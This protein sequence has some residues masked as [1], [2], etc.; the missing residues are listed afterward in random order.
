[1]GKRKRMWIDV[2]EVLN[3]YRAKVLRI[4]EGM[5]N[6]EIDPLDHPGTTW[7]V[8]SVFNDV[9]RTTL[10]GIA[11][12]SGFCESLLVREGAQAAIE[13]LRQHVDL[14]VVTSPF[15]SRHWVFERDEWLNKYFGFERNRVVHTSAK[16]LIGA[17][18]CLDDKHSNVLE[19]HAEHPDGLAMIWPTH[20]TR[21]IPTPDGYLVKDWA[22]VID[23][24]K[25][26]ET[27]STVME[28]LDDREWDRDQMGNF[29]QECGAAMK[30]SGIPLHN[31]NCRLDEVLTRYRKTR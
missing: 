12:D 29:C 1:M 30:G 28:L 20:H 2:D 26:F 31:P 25:S 3:E 8:F 10:L 21:N 22:D 24:V 18:I 27:K 15:H 16:Y 23:R 13:E 19:W 5:F 17:D 4:A 14:F 11:S 7:D 9:E 6:R